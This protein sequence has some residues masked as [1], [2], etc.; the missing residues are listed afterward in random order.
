[1]RKRRAAAAAA[2]SLAIGGVVLMRTGKPVRA[3]GVALDRSLVALLP[4]H[5][6]SLVGVDVE[7][8]KRTPVWRQ[9]EER[10]ARDSHFEELARETGFD[11]RR[12]VYELLVASGGPGQLVALACGSFDT[13]AWTRVLKENKAVSETYR[14]FELLG[15]EDAHKQGRFAFLDNRTVLAGS[16][17]EVL[18][19]IDRKIGGGPSLLA[20]TAL[21]NRA[22]AI[23]GTHPVW[24]VSDSPGQI[25][26]RGFGGS[27]DAR[28]SNF[29]RIFSSMRAATF[30]LDL[31]FGLELRASGVC[32]TAEDAR[33][34]A[35]A[36]RGVVALGRLSASQ[37]DPELMAVFDGIRVEQRGNELDVAVRLDPASLEKLLQQGKPRRARG[38]PRI[39]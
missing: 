23:S 13:A 11:P 24:A 26:A 7:R 8:L 19:A 27:P 39:D 6:T 2:A 20:N 32:G 37:Q 25:V 10:S 28:V 38:R 34:L 12:D 5:A 1:M 35:D 17:T 29:A 16:R 21:L 15:P 22:Q 3:Q 33:T 36:A 14:G 9:F 30:A 31:S 18:A 4:P